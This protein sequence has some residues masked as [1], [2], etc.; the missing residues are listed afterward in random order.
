MLQLSQKS[1]SLLELNCQLDEDIRTDII[2]SFNYLIK[3]FNQSF[4][5]IGNDNSYWVY[6]PYN[7]IT[8]PDELSHL[9][10]KNLI[11]LT[12]DTK[13]KDKFKEISLNNY[14]CDIQTEYSI[15]SK[16]AVQCLLP[17]YTTHLCENEFSL[18]TATRTKYRSRL[19]ASFDM[20]IQL[21]TIK[22]DL[23]KI[24]QD[25]KKLNISF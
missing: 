16:K 9:E 6:N 14:W 19:D 2:C 21:S 17:F 12:S 7:V 8:K 25:I 23:E 18:Y 13:I 1:D 11:D 15:L 5:K 4:P 10:Y 3:T 24:I 22:P 20:R